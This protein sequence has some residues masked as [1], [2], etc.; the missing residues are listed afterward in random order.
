MC[1]NALAYILI[2]TE[3]IKKWILLDIPVIGMFYPSAYLQDA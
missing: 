1:Q 2:K 3:Y